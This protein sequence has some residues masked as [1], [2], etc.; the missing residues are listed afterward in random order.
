[1]SQKSIQH[2]TITDAEFLVCSFGYAGTIISGQNQEIDV[3]RSDD[4][5]FPDIEIRVT[6]HREGSQMDY[7][8]ISLTD[9]RGAP[10]VMTSVKGVAID[11][12]SSE[13]MM[14]EAIESDDK[15]FDYSYG[16]EPYSGKVA[17]GT[18]IP[19]K[20]GAGYEPQI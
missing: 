11:F 2:K 8:S 14:F 19:C 3:F 7:S 20:S 13:V 10:V 18:F 5:E 17:P 6:L 9:G 12:E 16:R 15:S 1:M 4:E